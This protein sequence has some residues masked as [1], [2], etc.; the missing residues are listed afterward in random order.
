MRNFL[1]SKLCPLSVLPL[2]ALFILPTPSI[3]SSFPSP[4]ASHV[5]KHHFR[6]GT[7]KKVMGG[8][9]FLSCTFPLQEYLI[10]YAR[11]FFLGY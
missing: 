11:T 6:D 7:I 5:S 3:T 4:R 10:P 2:S 1:T 8:G 9:G